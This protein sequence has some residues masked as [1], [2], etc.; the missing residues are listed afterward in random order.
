[1]FSREILGSISFTAIEG[2]W[3]GEDSDAATRHPDPY[4]CDGQ[5]RERRMFEFDVKKHS[6]KQQAGISSQQEWQVRVCV[7]MNRL[8]VR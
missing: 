7:C 3:N 1:M 5:M 2:L 4:V 8:Q 6:R